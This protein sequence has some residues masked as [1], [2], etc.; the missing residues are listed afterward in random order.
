MPRLSHILLNLGV[1]LII[2]GALILS[3]C[4]A[5]DGQ[6]T[7]DD[8]NNKAFTF[9]NGTVFHPALT[10]ATFLEFTDNANTFTLSSAGGC[11][12][13]EAGTPIV[14][15]ASGSNRFGSCILTVGTSTYTPEMGPQVD[16]VIT[17]NPC[18]FDSTNKTLTVSNGSITATSSPAIAR[19]VSA[20][21]SD[22]N[23][24]TFLFASGQVFNDAL[25]NIAVTLKFTDN[26]NSF[27]LTASNNTGSTATGTSIISSGSCTLTVTDTAFS[28]GTG[29]QHDD[30]ITFSTCQVNGSTGA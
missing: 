2:A 26:A 13:N 22:L 16:D 24:T 10:S 1:V 7:A 17:L 25:V 4:A 29:P 5:T 14:C 20:T 27:T 11:P 23:N 15:T 19:L 21:A 9:P 3:G 12:P 6:A 30:V 18:N 8:V 28:T